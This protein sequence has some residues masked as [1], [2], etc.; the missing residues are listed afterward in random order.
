MGRD[1]GA[2]IS[3]PDLMTSM[4]CLAWNIS[5]LI[6]AIDTTDI[7]RLSVVSAVPV[8]PAFW[9]FASGLVGLIGIAKKRKFH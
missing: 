2:Y 1:A 4:T 5:Y 3:R 6:D 8:P 7:V 9:L